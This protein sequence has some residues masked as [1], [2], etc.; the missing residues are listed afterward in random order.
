MV[1]VEIATDGPVVIALLLEG[2]VTMR[3]NDESWISVVVLEVGS[4]W[5][6]WL[7]EYQRQAPNSVVAVQSVDESAQEFAARVGRRMAEITRAQAMLHVGLLVSNCS[8]EA[9]QVR[10]RQEVCRS[11]LRVMVDEQHG[12]LILAADVNAGDDM[13]HEL[14]A[15]AGELCD[16]IRGAEVAVR[17]RFSS[18]APTSGVMHTAV[19]VLPDADDREPASFARQ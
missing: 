8:L 17:V 9:E 19:P 4:T 2:R 13:R 3:K 15:L 6:R 18:A 7:E 10:M 5:P 16:E 12:E 14:F 11:M 1:D